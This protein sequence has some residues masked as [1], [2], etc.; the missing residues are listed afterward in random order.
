[1]RNGSGP[2]KDASFPVLLM[3]AVAHS[4]R[5]PTSVAVGSHYGGLDIGEKIA[6][7][8]AQVNTAPRSFVSPNGIPLMSLAMSSSP[9][10]DWKTRAGTLG[11]SLELLL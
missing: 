10:E 5:S 2:A 4:G 9:S 3:P 11:D 1:M 8:K 6:K 7:A